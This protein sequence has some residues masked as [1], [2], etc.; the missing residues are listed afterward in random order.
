M[1]H[2]ELEKKHVH[3]VYNT[4]ASD[5]SR[6]R[7]SVWG[8]V[9]QFLNSLESSSLIA[10]VGCGNGKNFLEGDNKFYVGFDITHKFLEEIVIK[11]KYEGVCGN[12]LILPFKQNS[13]D[14]VV[15]IA[16]LHHLSSPDRRL[17]VLSELIR[18]VKPHGLI[19]ITVWALE[20]PK[21][22]KQQFTQQENYVKWSLRGSD[23][24]FLRYY[25]VFKKGELEDL[26]SCF[27]NVVIKKSYY[28]RGNW[29]V[30]LEKVK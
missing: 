4:I 26:I 1:D 16:V 11:T 5:F 28:E 10:D 13:F 17:Q 9:K 18:I 14:A 19:L 22:E 2:H 20:Q 15:N 25:Y 27:D 6:T 30:V 8:E 12:A 3:D 29:G 23:E 21:N 24:V 7:W